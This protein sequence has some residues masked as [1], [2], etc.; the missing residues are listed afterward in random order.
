M[1]RSV[2]TGPCSWSNGVL[3]ECLQGYT[4]GSVFFFFS[5]ALKKKEFSSVSYKKACKA[6][7]QG[8]FWQAALIVNNR[9]VLGTLSNSGG[10]RAKS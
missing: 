2:G 9:T 4:S 8:N 7:T 10:K 1:L 3:V 6:V 5:H